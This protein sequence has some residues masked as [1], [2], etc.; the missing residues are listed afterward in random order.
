ME[1]LICCFGIGN[2]KESINEEHVPCFSLLEAGICLGNSYQLC[3]PP[4]RTP[5]WD[6]FQCY[7]RKTKTK[8]CRNP[9]TFTSHH[10]QKDSASALP[11]LFQVTRVEPA[12]CQATLFHICPWWVR[13]N[14]A[15]GFK[16]LAFAQAA[17]LQADFFDRRLGGCV[18]MWYVQTGHFNWE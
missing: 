5:E 17:S 12:E 16:S 14:K 10:L 13:F 9:T 2:S 11:W 4:R 3:D 1:A 15:E 18:T 6:G 7:P 8:I